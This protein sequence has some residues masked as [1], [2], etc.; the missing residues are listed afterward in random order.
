MKSRLARLAPNQPVWMGTFHRFCARLLR[1]YGSLVGLSENY[2]IYDSDDS[3]KQLRL[4]IEDLR[5]EL[6]HA[7]PDAISSHI[8]WAKNNLI[9]I[10]GVEVQMMEAWH[11]VHIRPSFVSRDREDILPAQIFFSIPKASS[12]LGTRSCRTM[13]PSTTSF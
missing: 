5:I 6:T 11:R 9:R 13:P 3:A 12:N 10:Q 2:T 8:S 7:T 1:Q 4:A